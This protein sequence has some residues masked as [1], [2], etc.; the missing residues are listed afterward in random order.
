MN[1]FDTGASGLHG[2]A[3]RAKSGGFA[4]H[5]VFTDVSELKAKEAVLHY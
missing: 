2:Q 5:L 4:H 3:I 1:I